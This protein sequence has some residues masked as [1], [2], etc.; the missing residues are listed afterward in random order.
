MHAGGIV[1]SALR[2]SY[3]QQIA[4]PLILLSVV[5]ACKLNTLVRPFPRHPICRPYMQ[6]TTLVTNLIKAC[7]C[8]VYMMSCQYLSVL[9]FRPPFEASDCIYILK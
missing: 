7:T 3:S 2:S 4:D 6:K 9:I 5:P 1:I 8:I